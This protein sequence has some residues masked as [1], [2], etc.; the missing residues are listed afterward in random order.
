MYDFSPNAVL[1]VLASVIYDEADYIR[2]Y[3]EFIK[4]VEGNQHG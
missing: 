4:Y 3:D 2:S 1:M